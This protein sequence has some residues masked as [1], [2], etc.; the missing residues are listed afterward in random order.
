MDTKT[1]TAEAA[2]I[3]ALPAPGLEDL[4]AQL[5]ATPGMS[6]A[7]AANRIHRAQVEKIQ[8]DARDQA[9]AV[10]VARIL[11]QERVG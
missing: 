3:M 11:E 8:A 1:I 4:R 2:A 10:V 7:E 5:A 6:R 9:A